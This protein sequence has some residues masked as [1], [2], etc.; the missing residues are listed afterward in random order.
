MD[1]TFKIT[2]FNTPI[3]IVIIVKTDGKYPTKMRLLE[4]TPS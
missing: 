4:V 2:S 1:K 3:L